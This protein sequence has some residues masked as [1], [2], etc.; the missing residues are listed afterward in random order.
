MISRIRYP[1]IL[2]TLCIGL[3]VTALHNTAVLE[4]GVRDFAFVNLSKGFLQPTLTSDGY[5]AR[6]LELFGRAS[7]FDPA[8]YKPYQ[9]RLKGLMETLGKNA[10]DSGDINRLEVGSRSV[11]YSGWK[12]AVGRYLSAITQGPVV[13]RKDTIQE[14][15]GGCS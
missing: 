12:L 4:A 2:V 13:V 6:S 3:T 8:R 5:L 1:I 10:P 7:V 11:A 15:A 9:L 14:L